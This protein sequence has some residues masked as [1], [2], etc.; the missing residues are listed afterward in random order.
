MLCVQ[1]W[2]TASSFLIRSTNCLTTLIACSVCNRRNYKG[3]VFGD[4]SR[5]VFLFL[6]KKHVV[7]TH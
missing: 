5:I 2:H 7:G 1:K 4:N 3:G 6:H